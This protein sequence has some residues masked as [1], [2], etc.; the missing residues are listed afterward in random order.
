MLMAYDDLERE[1]ND[2]KNNIRRRINPNDTEAMRAWRERMRSTRERTFEDIERRASQLAEAAQQGR[3]R[4]YAGARVIEIAP[5]AGASADNYDARLSRVETEAQVGSTGR[6]LSNETSK[7]EPQNEIKEEVKTEKTVKVKKEKKAA[8]EEKPKRKGSSNKS[9]TSTRKPS[10]TEETSEDDEPKLKENS[11]RKKTPGKNKKNKSNTE[12]EE[13]IKEGK[14]NKKEKKCREKHKMKRRRKLELATDDS[15]EEEQERP[16]KNRKYKN[17]SG[18]ATEWDDSESSDS[19]AATERKSE[20]D[21]QRNS[22]HFKKWLTLEKFDGTTPLSIFLN[23]LD[24]C[25]KYNK[26]DVEDKA[27]HLRVSLKGNAAYTIDDEN[28]EGALYRKLIKRLKSRFGTEGQSSLYGSQMRTRK[29]GKEEPLQTL[30]HDINRMAGLAYPGNSS[31]HRELAAIDA[32][33]DAL[34]DSNI[35]MR[36]R[37]KEPKSLDHALHIAL[38]AEANTEAK[39]AIALEE[40]QSRANNYKA[41][42][43]QNATKPAGNAQIASVDSINDRCD[44][45]CEMFENIYK[46]KTP[47][48]AITPRTDA[49]MRETTPSTLV[50]NANITCYKSGNMG[51][52]ATSCPESTSGTKRGNAKGPMRCY[53]C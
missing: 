18:G 44:K 26:W 27:S 24:T 9:R 15:S 48:A 36:V 31:V 37:D 53:A 51:H 35:R 45:I 5:I 34:G 6:R 28:L 52:Y 46:D 16:K 40:S 13:D 43:V 10:S 41:R 4:T 12:S 29:R 20:K 42:V 11:A 19:D 22:R 17:A 30:Y 49:A 7:A 21:K 3:D 8:D 25:A 1:M 38:L 39:P 50:A 14:K 32:F 2:L 33:I 47:N 23:Q